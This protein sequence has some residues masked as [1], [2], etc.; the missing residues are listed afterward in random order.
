MKTSAQTIVEFGAAFGVSGMYWLSGLKNVQGEGHLYSFEVNKSWA[1][2]ARKNLEF[3]GDNFTLTVGL[4]EDCVDEVMGGR[5]IDLAFIDG[6]HTSEWVI[7]QLQT[8]VERSAKNAVIILDDIAFSE[9]MEQCWRTVLEKYS[10]K[11]LCAA[12]LNDR[13]GIIQLR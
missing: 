11:I 9:D 3:V 6:V 5:K 2:I 7:P 13:V 1:A 10:N 12:E 8:V 4:F